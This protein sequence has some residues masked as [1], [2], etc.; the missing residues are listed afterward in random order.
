MGVRL[1]LPQHRLQAQPSDQVRRLRLAALQRRLSV[2]AG[3][4]LAFWRAL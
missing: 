3:C 4:F 2:W 1:R